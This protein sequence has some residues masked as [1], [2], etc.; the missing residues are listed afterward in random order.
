MSFKEIMVICVP[1]LICIFHA[2]VSIRYY[3]RGWGIK[4]RF[5]GEDDAWAK[6]NGLKSER[7]NLLIDSIIFLVIGT[8]L[9]LFGSVG[10]LDGRI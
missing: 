5:F 7:I 9:L 2:L 10:F 8:G 4:I 6:P 3:R 1:G